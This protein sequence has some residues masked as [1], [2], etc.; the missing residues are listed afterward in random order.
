MLFDR[1]AIRRTITSLVVTGLA[2]APLAVQAVTVND[3]YEV[4]LPIQG[5]REAAFVEAMKL[6]AVRVSLSKVA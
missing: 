3:L 6:V 2:L 1:R 5:S 4:T